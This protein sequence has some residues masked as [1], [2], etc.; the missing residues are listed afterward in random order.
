MILE[1]AVLPVLPGQETEFEAAFGRA[2]TII[3]SMP[4]FR[5]LALRRSLESPNLYLLLVEWDTVEDHTQGFRGSPQ[6]DEWRALLHRFYDPFPVVE[7]FVEV[8]F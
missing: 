1:H 7:H 4:G 3:S 2:R 6:Y 8:T 5:S